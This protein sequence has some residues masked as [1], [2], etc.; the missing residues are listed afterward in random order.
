[1]ELKEVKF[2]CKY[3]RGE[4]PCIPNKKRDKVCTTCGEYIP[5]KTKILIIKLGALGDVIRTTPLVVKYRELYPNSHV[6]WVT[7]SPD[8]LPKESIEKI[9]KYGFDAV[10]HVGYQ[11]YDIAI[12]LDK[13][14]EACALLS[15]VTAKEKYGFTWN[16]EKNHIDVATPA[17]VHKLITGLFD[18]ISKQNTKSYL[19][20][21]F[22]ICGLKFNYEPYLLN[23]NKELVEKWTLLKD[24]SQGKKIIGLNT[25]CGKRWSTRLWAADNWIALVR[26]L[27]HNNYYPVLLGGVDEDAQNNIYQH[28]TGAYYPGTYSLEEFIAITAN[29]DTIVSAVSMMMHI[30]TGLQKPL[31]LFNNIFNKHEFEMYGRGTIIEPTTGC[32]DYYGSVCSRENC[33]MNDISVESVYSAIVKFS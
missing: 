18:N 31:I 7:H 24:K 11:K 17:A 4:I 21:I 1:M 14:M 27:Q 2:D 16:H 12:N 28:E 22:E 13:E 33:C 23:V 9:L 6:T 10:N 26:Q 15:T 3:F 5:I 8:I 25:G 19:E 20:E 29:C 32:D 30:A